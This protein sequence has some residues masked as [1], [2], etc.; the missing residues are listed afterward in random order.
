MLVVI[1]FYW[2]FTQVAS[3]ILLSDFAPNN[4]EITVWILQISKKVLITSSVWFFA[5][6]WTVAHQAFSPGKNTELG[7]HYLLQGIFLTQGLNT[8]L[9]CRQILYPLRHQGSPAD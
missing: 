2:V 4:S 9:H 8:V 6:P 3:L 5:I 1:Y 7:S